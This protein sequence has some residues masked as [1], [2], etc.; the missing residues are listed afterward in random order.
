MEKVENTEKKKIRNF[1]VKKEDI[2]E[3]SLEEL[4]K[5]FEEL[6]E[7]RTTGEWEVVFKT[8]KNYKDLISIFTNKIEWK[9]NEAINVITAAESLKGVKN[10]NGYW[11]VDE[12][13]KITIVLK[14][15]DIESIVN[16]GFR[17]GGK[18]VHQAKDFLNALLPFTSVVAKMRALD[19]E[20]QKIQK[21]IDDRKKPKDE[22]TDGDELILENKEK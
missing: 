10:K 9:G 13:G 7:A 6:I 16:L 3:K 21:E 4:E 5:K 19:E 18:G 2:S 15:H 22:I 20:L 12:D 17:H 1:E 14:A 8:E 11:D